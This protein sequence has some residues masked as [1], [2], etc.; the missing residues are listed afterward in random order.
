MEKMR[1]YEKKII[2]FFK[3]SARCVHQFLFYSWAMGSKIYLPL[4]AMERS[5][6]GAQFFNTTFTFIGQDLE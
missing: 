5:S 1:D 6:I 4:H 2:C 3:K